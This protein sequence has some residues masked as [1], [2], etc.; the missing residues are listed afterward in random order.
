LCRADGEGPAVG[1]GRLGGADEP[2]TGDLG[3]D[4]DDVEDDEDSDESPRGKWD[5]SFGSRCETDEGG[6]SEIYGG[7]EEDRSLQCGASV[8]VR[9]DMGANVI[10]TYADDHEIIQYEEHD[11]ERP[12]MRRNT[13]AIAD[14]LHRTPER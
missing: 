6:E 7:G 8:C 12:A 11:H 5:D 4:G 13:H 3:G 9:I 1:G 10:C 14:D 2:C